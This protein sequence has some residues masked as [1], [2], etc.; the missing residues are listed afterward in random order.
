VAYCQ[1]ARTGLMDDNNDMQWCNGPSVHFCQGW[2]ECANEIATPLPGIRGCIIVT[3]LL[4][5][6]HPC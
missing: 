3:G 2:P 1:K 4:G 6:L 5:L